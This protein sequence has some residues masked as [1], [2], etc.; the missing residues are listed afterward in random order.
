LST[1]V[2]INASDLITNSRADLNTNFSN[3]NSDKIETSYIDTDTA[4]AANSDVKIPSQKAVKT[5]IDTSGGA[6]ASTTV[7]GIVEEATSAEMIAGT[8]AGGTGARLFLNPSLVAETGTD[9]IVKTKSTGFIDGSIIS[10]SKKIYLSTTEVT[11]TNGDGG[12]GAGTE[13]TCFS[14]TVAGGILSTNGGLKLKMYIQSGNIATADNAWTIRLKYGGSTLVTLTSFTNSNAVTGLEGYFEGYILADG[15]TNTQ[16]ATATCW[17]IA[18]DDS[19]ATADT[20][21]SVSKNF[22]GGSVGSGAVD[23]TAS[24]TLAISVQMT[25]STDNDAVIEWLIVE[26]IS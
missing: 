10:T 13:H 26:S 14:T 16:K 3:L 6:N 5:Y 7:R 2:T 15:A 18:K 20:S 19:E 12:S 25:N 23:S 8:A 21:V 17:M 4:L 24:Q 1:I 11:F 22:F 9:K